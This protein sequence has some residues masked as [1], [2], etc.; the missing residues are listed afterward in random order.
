[1][2]HIDQVPND[3]AKQYLA[4]MLSD[5]FNQMLKTIFPTEDIYLRYIQPFLV[6]PLFKP[7]DNLSFYEME[8]FFKTKAEFQYY[9]RPN[10]ALDVPV[11]KQPGRLARLPNAFTHWVYAATNKKVMITD[12]QGWRVGDG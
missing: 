12:L 9:N 7:A 11:G 1:M 8:H 10:E 6:L 5:Y 4:L 2:K 3:I